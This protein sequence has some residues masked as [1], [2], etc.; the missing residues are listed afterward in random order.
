MEENLIYVNLLILPICQIFDL[1][2]HPFVGIEK[3]D[4][5]HFKGIDTRGLEKLEKK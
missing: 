4:N 2:F 5:D 1:I 3:H